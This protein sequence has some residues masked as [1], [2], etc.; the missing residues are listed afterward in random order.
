M[1]EV[2]LQPVSY[3]ELSAIRHEVAVS[4]CPEE[5]QSPEFLVVRYFGSYRTAAAG[6]RR[7]V[8]PRRGRGGAGGVVVLLDHPRL[9]GTGVPLGRQHGLDQPHRVGPGHPAAL[10][11]GGR[12][13]RPVPGRPAVAAAGRVPGV[14]RRV[15]GGGVRPLP[16]EGEEH[17][18]QLRGET[19]SGR[20]IRC[21]QTRP[22]IGFESTKLIAAAPAVYD[23]S[24]ALP[25]ALHYLATL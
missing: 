20:T 10:A 24:P 7:P 2:R 16:P 19:R 25:T 5:Y 11:A 14:V 3:A 22:L 12:S 6:H 13:R 17:K 18:R 4:E 8:H 1:G 23:R 15:A 9:P 21:R